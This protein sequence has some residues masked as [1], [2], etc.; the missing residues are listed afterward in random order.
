MKKLL[1]TLTLMVSVFALSAQSYTVTKDGETVESGTS[2]YIYGQGNM[3]GELGLAFEVIA[4]EP[5]RLQAEK[6]E[7]QVVEGTYNT[8]CLDL[9]YNPEIY[10]TP[11]VEFN[12]GDTKEFSM[13]Y[14]YNNEIGDVA[15]LE[16]HMTYYLYAVNDPDNKFVVNVIFKYSLDGV[17]DVTEAE[18]L[19]DAYPV[20]ASDVV[21]FDYSFNSDVNA[22]IAIYNIMGQEVMRN[23]ISGVSG[24]ASINVSDLADGV[25]FYSLIVNGVVEKSNK[26]IIRK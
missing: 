9:C 4:N 12:T 13:H 7:V 18:M 11:I 1:L 26:L 3:W 21:N 24:K 25:Y 8:L 2:Y 10:V 15:G 22:A 19:S 5:V 23:V 14:M 20:P 17:E 16:Q 6:V